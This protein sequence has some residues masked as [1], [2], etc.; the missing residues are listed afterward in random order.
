MA[1]V[2]IREVY[3][4]VTLGLWQMD[5]SVEQLF[6]QYPH[7]QAYRS[8]MEEKYKNDGRKLEFLA[9]RSLMHAMGINGPLKH[10]SVGKPMV[11]GWHVS[12]SHTR[13]YAAF[14]VSRRQDVAVDVEYVSDRVDRIANKFLRKDE[15]PRNTL[16]RLV[17]WCAKETVYK[18][19]SSDN[20]KFDEMRICP[21]DADADWIC[22]VENL[23]RKSV[24]VNV[25]FEIAI[26]FVLTYAVLSEDF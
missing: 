25:D 26:D 24:S 11:D 9:I 17:S 23:K 7:L 12:V 3:P 20:L 13:G 8:M 15:R 19:F 1:V 6:S 4:G 14:I 16:E 18:L 10:N 5:E 21:F 22:Q 2:N